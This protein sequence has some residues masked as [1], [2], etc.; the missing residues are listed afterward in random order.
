MVI[1][2]Y[3]YLFHFLKVGVLNVVV[4]LAVV[5]LLTGAGVAVAGETLAGTL[6]GTACLLVHLGTGCL[7]YAVEVVDGVVDGRYV[8]A[9][10][11]VAEL[12]EG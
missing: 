3:R 7:H 12:L 9:L 1:V 2:V 6:L 5:L 4:G 10:V 8:T 11:G